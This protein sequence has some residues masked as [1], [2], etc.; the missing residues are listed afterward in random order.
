MVTIYI[1]E[2]DADGDLLFDFKKSWFSLAD[3]A[4][5]ATAYHKGRLEHPGGSYSLAFAKK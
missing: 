1:K 2:Y 5:Y 3:A 4:E